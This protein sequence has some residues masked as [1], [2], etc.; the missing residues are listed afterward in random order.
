MTAPA[1]IEPHLN[2]VRTLVSGDG[3]DLTFVDLQEGRLT[4]ALS[5]EDAGC[6]DCVIPKDLLSA[7][8]L[9][10]LSGKVPALTEVVLLDPRDTA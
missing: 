10:D 1:E 8:I 6:L 2:A 4:L 7:L 9:A 3:A 5:V